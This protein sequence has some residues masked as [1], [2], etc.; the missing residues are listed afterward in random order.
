MSLLAESLIL[1]AMKRTRNL[2]IVISVLLLLTGAMTSTY[3]ATR[4]LTQ[5]ACD[6]RYHEYILDLDKD[7][8]LTKYY[9]S[10]GREN[11]FRWEVTS[12]KPSGKKRNATKVL[13]VWFGI[14]GI[15][16]LFGTVGV[17]D[18]LR[19]NSLRFISSTD[20]G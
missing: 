9:R 16:A 8:G 20:K 2:Q 13:G 3:C 12:F 11:F 18:G 4:F 6:E 5:W 15:A 14:G 1:S 7:A 17:W 10:K 19:Q